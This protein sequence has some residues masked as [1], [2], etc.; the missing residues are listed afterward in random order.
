MISAIK[1]PRVISLAAPRLQGQLLT[2]SNGPHASKSHESPVERPHRFQ[3][4]CNVLPNA[5]TTSRSQEALM[6]VQSPPGAR[7]SCRRSCHHGRQ[8]AHIVRLNTHS[9]KVVNARI[10]TNSGGQA[11]C[12]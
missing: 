3:D 12:C 10:G 1:K 6:T 2:L 9:F 5:H 8:P 4:H 7:G 11:V